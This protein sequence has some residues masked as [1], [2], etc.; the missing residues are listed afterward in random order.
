MIVGTM[1]AHVPNLDIVLMMAV[2][3]LGSLLASSLRR[4][5]RRKR[6]HRIAADRDRWE[7]VLFY[8]GTPKEW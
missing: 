8:F 5:H 1:I 7:R 3:V 6:R 2:V 4:E